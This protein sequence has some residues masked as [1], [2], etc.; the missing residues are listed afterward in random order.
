[1][2]ESQPVQAFDEELRAIWILG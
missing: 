2:H 1:M